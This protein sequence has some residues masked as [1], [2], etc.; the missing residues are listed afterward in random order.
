M[1]SPSITT[2][3]TATGQA[4]PVLTPFATFIQTHTQ[5][6]VIYSANFTIIDNTPP[7]KVAGSTPSATLNLKSLIVFA[8]GV[9]CLV[10]A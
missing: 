1:S 9:S 5:Q 6:I 3:T 7:V 4:A 10:L 2:S 8:L